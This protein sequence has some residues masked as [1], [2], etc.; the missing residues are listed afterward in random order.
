MKQ[1][2]LSV[3]VHLNIDLLLKLRRD[4]VLLVHARGAASKE[5]IYHNTAFRTAL[6]S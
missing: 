1:I 6:M 3:T 2:I 4:L 5:R